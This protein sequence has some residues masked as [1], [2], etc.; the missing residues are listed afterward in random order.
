METATKLRIDREFQ[1]LI[2][3]LT[4][5]EYAGLEASVLA[6]GVL[7]PLV[8]WNGTVVDGH[9]R[10]RIC[11]EHGIEYVTRNIELDD[12]DAA[13]LWIIGHQLARR[14]LTIAQRV[15]LVNQRNE[16]E[17]LRTEAKKREL[18]GVKPDP[19][20]NSDKGPID[21]IGEI[22]EQAGVARSTA[23]KVLTVN[24]D[25][26]EDTK[27]AMFS[28]ET[29]INKAYRAVKKQKSETELA[30]TAGQK[31]K[32]PKGKFHTIVI[33][34]PWP[35]AKILRDVR[36]NQVG[37]DYPTMSVDEIAAFPVP[38]MAY[39]NCHIY[40]WTTQKRLRESF[41]I[42]DAWGFRQL[43]TMVWHKPGGFQPVGLPQYNAEFILFG[44]KGVLPFIET[45]AYSTCFAAPRREHSRK[46][47]EFY[48]LVA[49][50]SPAPRID[51]F[52]REQRDGWETFGN[53]T[54]RF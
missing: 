18:A 46:P 7:M 54:T 6:E 43:F 37:M 42:L 1:E 10:L 3:P 24:R 2:P 34:P 45:K 16:I 47:D 9:H 51:V 40:L 14:N 29:S 22:A 48:E 25:G 38:D 4:N 17:G 41:D 35:M 5:E 50:V 49:R 28:G 52:S 53:D 19:C 32:L 11:R 44:R 31:V 21:V 30:K 27:Q 12:R 23:A 36:P 39:K 13:K 33:D 15:I 8:E 20:L 26:D